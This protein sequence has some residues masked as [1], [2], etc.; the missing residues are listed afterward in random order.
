MKLPGPYI[1]GRRV[2]SAQLSAILPMSGA[3]GGGM[4]IRFMRPHIVV[5]GFIVSGLVCGLAFVG[6]TAVCI[7]GC[8]SSSVSQP[9]APQRTPAL[10]GPH[11]Y[12]GSASAG[13]FLTFTVTPTSSGAGA[14]SYTDLTNNESGQSIP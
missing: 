6:L 5:A 13:D 12:L 2:H 14:I 1:F 11:S 4:K 9:S 10:T 8:T 3:A 7:N